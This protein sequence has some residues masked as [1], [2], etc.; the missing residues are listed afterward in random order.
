MPAASPDVPAGLRQLQV[1]HELRE[2]LHPDPLP[3]KPVGAGGGR[4]RPSRP[5]VAEGADGVAHHADQ[6]FAAL[7]AAAVSFVIG[8]AD[9]S[10]RGPLQRLEPIQKGI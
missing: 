7:F 9:S 3:G 6:H 5:R 1:A 10:K 8:E 2:E 4:A